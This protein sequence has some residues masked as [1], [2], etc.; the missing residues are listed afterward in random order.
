MSAC[1]SMT[2]P[3]EEGMKLSIDP[4]Q[5]AINKGRYQRVMGRLIYVAHT[6]LDLAHTLSVLSQYM[7]DPEENNI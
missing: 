3:L 2:T 1:K 6:R 4:N 7:H 5:V